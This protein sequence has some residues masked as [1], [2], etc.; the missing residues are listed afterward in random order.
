M[1]KQNLLDTIDYYI[2]T[3]QRS[4]FISPPASTEQNKRL[5]ALWRLRKM[6]NEQ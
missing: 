3:E 5:E 4:T 1:N 6:V 2:K